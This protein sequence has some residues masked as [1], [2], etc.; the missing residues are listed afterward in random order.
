MFICDK[1]FDEQRMF[2]SDKGFHMMGMAGQF[3]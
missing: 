3:L 2:I 1:G